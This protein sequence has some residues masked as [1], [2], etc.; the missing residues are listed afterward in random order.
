MAARK[1]L[2]QTELNSSSSDDDDDYFIIVQS[3]SNEKGKHGGSVHGHQVLCR[4]REGG[5][6]RMFQDY[7]ADDLTYPDTI[8]VEGSCT[9]TPI[10]VLR[11]TAR[12]A[13]CGRHAPRAHDQWVTYGSYIHV[14]PFT[15]PLSSYFFP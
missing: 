14:I 2:L 7:L 9:F 8:S 3:F 11:S 13:P 12:S 15:A 5:H 4:D 1:S 6:K 10:R